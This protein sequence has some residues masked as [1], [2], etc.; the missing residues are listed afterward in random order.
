LWVIFIVFFNFRAGPIISMY[1]SVHPRDSRGVVL[2]SAIRIFSPPA[3]GKKRALMKPVGFMPDIQNATDIR[4][5]PVKDSVS[6]WGDFCA[7]MLQ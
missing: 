4:C 1:M 2:V 6:L 3:T 5:C 7:T